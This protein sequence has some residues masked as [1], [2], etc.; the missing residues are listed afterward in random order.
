[1]KPRI[2]DIKFYKPGEG[3]LNQTLLAYASC[4]MNKQIYFT[5]VVSDIL[6]FHVDVENFF[7]CSQPLAPSLGLQHIS[8]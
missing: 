7:R 6:A 4:V 3:L 1:M 5:V 2:S 8:A